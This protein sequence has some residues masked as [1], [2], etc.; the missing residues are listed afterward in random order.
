MFND[1]AKLRNNATEND[2]R[3]CNEKLLALNI[4]S[5]SDYR[6]W[7]GKNH[8]DKIKDKDKDKVET[9]KIFQEISGCYDIIYGKNEEDCKKKQIREEPKGW[10]VPRREEPRREE[11]RREE[12]KGWNVP[13]RE[14]PRR[15]EPKGWNVPRS[16][17]NAKT[18]DEIKMEQLKKEREIELTNLIISDYINK[19][20]KILDENFRKYKPEINGVLSTDVLESIKPFLFSQL[21]TIV[22]NII[23]RDSDANNFM[24]GKDSFKY[25]SIY[26]ISNLINMHIFTNQV[27]NYI[28]QILRLNF[29]QYWF[30]I[31]PPKSVKPDS[32]PRQRPSYQSHARGRRERSK[33]PPRQTPRDRSTSPP[34]LRKKG[35]QFPDKEDEPKPDRCGVM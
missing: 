15:E 31:S 10:N 5:N 23:T 29:N 18:H 26:D 9:N 24:N 35:G 22:R 3:I 2:C 17:F 14:E 34:P 4:N 11:P 21:Q 32:P 6:K 13:R 27:I 20:N 28:I 30:P 19:F 1:E 8:P 12:P 25:K 7:T 33:T 16:K